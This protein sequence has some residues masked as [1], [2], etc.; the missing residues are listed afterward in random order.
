MKKL[1]TLFMLAGVITFSASAQDAFVDGADSTATDST[2]VDS[3]AVDTSSDE[4]A[5]E[6]GRAHV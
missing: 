2:T 6:I 1:L 4:E 3:A 5:Y